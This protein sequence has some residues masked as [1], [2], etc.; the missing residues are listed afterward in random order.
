MFFWNNC[1]WLVTYVFEINSI[2]VIAHCFCLLQNFFY[3]F[4]PF[5]SNNYFYGNS[6]SLK[7]CF[8]YRPDQTTVLFFLLDDS[9]LKDLCGKR[10][11]GSETFFGGTNGIL[12]TISF[13]MIR[14]L[15]LVFFQWLFQGCDYLKYQQ[16]FLKVF[17]MD[18]R[19]FC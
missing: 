18:H 1:E 12:K 11:L 15:T 19:N 7:K 9:W 4:I 3:R 17:H 16:K 14:T 5:V 6:A 10:S 8:V 13:R 2:K